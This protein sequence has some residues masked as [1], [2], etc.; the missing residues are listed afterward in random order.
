MDQL[1]ALIRSRN[2]AYKTEQTYCH[3]VKRFIPITLNIRSI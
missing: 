2:L 1:R 3:W